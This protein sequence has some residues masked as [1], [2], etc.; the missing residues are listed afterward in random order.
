VLQYTS[1]MSSDA[2]ISLVLIS[3]V[4]L[5][6]CYLLHQTGRGGGRGGTPSRGKQGIQ[7]FKGKKTSFED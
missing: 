3:V 5:L 1:L 6:L 2:H 7:D 4:S